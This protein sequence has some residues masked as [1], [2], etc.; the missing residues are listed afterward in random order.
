MD[1]RCGRGFVQL[2]VTDR[3]DDMI[4]P[5]SFAVSHPDVFDVDFQGSVHGICVV[6]AK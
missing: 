3:M 4:W 5:C 1:V 6:A 2:S